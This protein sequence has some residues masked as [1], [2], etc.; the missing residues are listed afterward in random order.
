M[1][2]IFLRLLEKGYIYKDSMKLPYC[3]VEQ[4][5]LPDRYVEG[6]CPLCGAEARAATSATTAAS[7][8]RRPSCYQPRCRICGS[9]AG[10]AGVGALLPQADR[11]QP[12]AQGV[13]RRTKSTGAR[14]SSTSRWACSNEGLHDRAITRDIEWGIPVPLPGF[15]GKRIYVWFEAVI[16]YLSAAKEWAQRQ[17]KP[18]AWRDFWQDPKCKSYYFIGKDN[19]PFHT[20]IWP[21]MLMGYGDLNLP[22]D[23]PANEFLNFGGAKALHEPRHG[24]LAARLSG[25][26]RS[27]SAALPS[28]R[29][30]AGDRRHRFHRGRVRP[31]QQRRA[32]GDLGQPGAPR[33]DLH[34][35]SL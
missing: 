7:P 16:G 15:E 29:Q 4:R 8:R 17:G 1:Q 19:I 5:F 30:H 21:A 27:R 35:P 34:L 6:T 2:D 18:D 11:L 33:P 25:E 12:A 28:L 14:T 13:A 23:V 26:V 9:D 10:V 22:Y 20:I 32:G 31:A 3:P 24:R